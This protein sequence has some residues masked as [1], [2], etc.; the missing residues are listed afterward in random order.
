MGYLYDSTVKQDHEACS[1]QQQY[2]K[3]L[4]SKAFNLPSNAFII[5]VDEHFYLSKFNAC[6]TTISGFEHRA[7]L[8]TSAPICPLRS[9]SL[10]ACAYLYYLCLLVRKRWH[11]FFVGIVYCP[12]PGIHR[13]VGTCQLVPGT[14][15]TLT[16]TT[17]TIK[18][19]FIPIIIETNIP[20]L[21]KYNDD[22]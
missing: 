3:S 5:L 1:L 21:H 15:G 13:D 7:L 14:L 12:Y 19:L 10:G 20:V 8:T 6:S 4:E 18:V 22:K 2:G 16:T 9:T 11:S 17:G